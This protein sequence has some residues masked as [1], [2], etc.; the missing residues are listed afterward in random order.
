MK[1]QSQQASALLMSGS[2]T[3]EICN[4]G[5]LNGVVHHFGSGA[6]VALIEHRL[7]DDDG[8]LDVLGGVAD[9]ALKAARSIA[10]GLVHE[11]GHVL[12]PSRNAP[13]EVARVGAALVL[14]RAGLKN[15]VRVLLLDTRYQLQQF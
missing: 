14:L 15:D 1:S 12:R 4:V 2:N 10:V 8:R 3:Y 5:D 7:V 11:A 6:A 9:V 13:L